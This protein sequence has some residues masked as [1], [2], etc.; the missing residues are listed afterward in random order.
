MV[1]QWR[2]LNMAIKGKLPR[3]IAN[4]CYNSMVHQYTIYVGSDRIF[5]NS[6]IPQPLERSKVKIFKKLRC[7]NTTTGK[8][9][10]KHCILN[11]FLFC[12][13]DK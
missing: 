10:A 7:T 11:P 13:F 12:N 3:P 5:E 8:V 9:Y 6:K 2:S 4:S 1:N